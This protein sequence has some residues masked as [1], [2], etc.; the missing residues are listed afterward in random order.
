MKREN[1]DDVNVI[2]MSYLSKNPLL[3]M[4]M[5]V[6]IKRGTAQILYADEN[7]VCLIETE[8]DAYMLSASDHQA[9]Q[10]LIELIPPDEMVTFHQEFMLEYLKA[11]MVY[12]SFLENYQAVYFSHAPLPV[13]SDLSVQALDISHFEMVQANYE[14]D[15]GAEYLEKRI[16]AGELFGGHV[17]TRLVGF[18]GIHAEGSIGLLQVFKGFRGK[19]Y[20]AALTANMVNYQLSRGCMPFEQIGIENSASLAIARKL[21]FS[22]SPERVFWMF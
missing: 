6:P 11:R 18:V 7:A 4:G 16:E 21:G 9:S 3:H 19:G 17:N 8:S 20:G 5:I 2:A 10:R 13:L 15:V 1:A 12:S 22:T 14:V